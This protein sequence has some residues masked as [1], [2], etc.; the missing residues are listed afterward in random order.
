MMR[1]GV[2]KKAGSVALPKDGYEKTD[3]HQTV[4]GNTRMST[5][6]A[7]TPCAQIEAI[8]SEN[9]FIEVTARS[10]SVLK[11]DF[12]AIAQQ[13]CKRKRKDDKKACM[14]GECEGA[15]ASCVDLP[16]FEPNPNF[17]EHP[18]DHGKF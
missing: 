2:P 12:G 10:A 17:P 11:E 5:R 6:L 9:E 14:E 3:N 13:R 18:N 4:P 1:A 16:S 7:E 8:T 15:N